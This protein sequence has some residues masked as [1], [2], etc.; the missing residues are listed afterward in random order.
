M[1]GLDTNV[2]VRYLVQDDPR[3]ARAAT[4]IVSARTASDRAFVSLIVLVELWWVLRSAYGHS[5]D[6]VTGCL[7]GL[8]DSVE[9][10]VEQ[11][12]AARNALRLTRDGADFA[13]ALIAQVCNRAGCT[14]VMTFDRGAVRHT[15]MSL[16]R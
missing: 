6:D 13:D 2:L 11:P 14:G 3:Q 16:L 5:R 4:R 8:L 9:V 7:D 10:A 12:E 1:I 15:A